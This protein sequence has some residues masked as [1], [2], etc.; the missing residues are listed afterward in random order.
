MKKIILSFLV[1]F[2]FLIP[3]LSKAQCGFDVVREKQLLDPTFVLQEQA[4]EL[5]IKNFIPPSNVTGKAGSVLTIP[6]VVHVLHKGEAVGS[7]TNISDAQIQSAIDRLNEVYRGLDPNSPLD[8]EIEFALAQRDP[9]CN[10]TNGINRVLATGVAG[11]SANGVFMQSVGADEN[12]LKD[13]SKWPET[14]YCNIWI[15]SE[16]D[17]N[18]GGA[19]IQ[20]YANFFN[21]NAYEG[22]VMMASV[23]GYDPGNT[24]GWGLNSNGD[25]GTVV[26]EFG[27]YFHLY[28]T[29]QGDDADSGP[30]YTAQCPGDAVV[31][32][33]SD[34]CSDTE[35][36]K[37]LT[38]TCPTDNDCNGGSAYGINTRNNYMSY[39]SCTDRL[40]ADQKTRVTAAMTGTSIVASKGA[41]APDP[42]YS[43][44]VAVCATNSVSTGFSG[45]T[46]V[47]LNGTNFSS[48]SSSS[49]GGNIDNSA[50]CSG[51][52]EINADIANTINA[53]VFPSNFQQLGVWIDWNDDGDFNDDAEQQHLSEDIA[54]GSIVPINITYP[55][56][57]PYDDY[58]RIRFITDT[59]NRH[60]S[61]TINSS[62]YASINHGQ[63]EDYAIYVQPASGSA[64][65]ADFSAS[66]T[67]VC[68]SN[69]ITFTDS[70]T[71]S[72]TSWLWNFGDGNS[73]TLQN[74][75]HVYA[76]AGT[77]T[78]T[79][80]ATNASGSDDEVKTNHITV[81]ANP[82]L[83]STSSSDETCTGNDGTATVTPSPVG[84]YTYSWNTAPAQT[85][86]TATGLSAAT[87]NVTVT[88]TV[89]TCFASTDVVVNNGC[90]AG[91][92]GPYFY[93][94]YCNKT[95]QSNE[96]S[97]CTAISGATNYEFQ[98][99]DQNTGTP[100][101]SI[102]RLGKNYFTLAMMSDWDYNTTYNVRVRAFVNSNWTD[103]GST[104]S[105][106]TP[107]FPLPQIFGKYCSKIVTS[108]DYMVCTTVPN[109][110]KY[111]FQLVDPV[112]S[113]PISSL[114]RIGKNFF[115]LDQMSGWDYNT[116]YN[117]RV[118]AFVGSSWMQYGLDCSITTSPAT[119]VSGDVV[120]RLANINEVEEE[121]VPTS[122]TIYPNPNQGEYLY[123]ELSDLGKDAELIVVD[124]Y[125]KQIHKEF[126]NTEESNYNTTVR[127]DQKLTSGF[128]LVTIISNGKSITKKLI[129]R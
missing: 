78:V 65:V 27:H 121:I 75:S 40:T 60:G 93:N 34:G 20:G 76:S 44:P 48:F 116:T 3:S 113:I 18:G 81:N 77:Y 5:K 55:S 111:E 104:C 10:A 45:I 31:G 98:L 52:F 62:C 16:I 6:V 99:V 120:A 26:H 100:V 36:H 4:N 57:I 119:I 12:E 84:S 51:Y 41:L 38:S 61:G 108:S 122:I 123:V 8:F 32:T 86:A 72:P 74:P 83:S 47:E 90:L 71:E 17:N 89:T 42:A 11:Y 109:G 67:S 127:F 39:F 58:V 56:T 92:P 43:A 103:F 110:T 97:V 115:K 125:G 66:S 124:V 80:T 107:S 54:A 7:G 87:Y 29:F 101:A 91:E 22:S 24:N 95:F 85:N 37:R 63:S 114:E 21:G 14:D 129:V 50:S 53:T 94:K 70:S 46:N 117:I 23:F 82:D 13:L 105:I 49:D 88:N 68:L 112:T 9:D 102:N 19:G 69:S 1:L 35:I 64:P 33:D 128:Y 15:V 73:S 96:Y 25:G 59:D 2:I 126:L 118:R 28:H 106:T 79:L 30:G